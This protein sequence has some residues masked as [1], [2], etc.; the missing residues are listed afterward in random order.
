[1]T[2]EDIELELSGG[3]LSARGREHLDGCASCRETARL[4]GL[5][6]L[7]PV[8]EVERMMMN[9]LASGT[10]AAWRSKESRGGT[11]RRAASLA[12]AAGVGA[13]VAS[14]AMVKLRPVPEPEVRVQTIHITPPELPDIELVDSNLSDDEVF[15]D[16]GWPSPTEGDL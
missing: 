10:Q 7:P 3:T 12:M 2:C 8:T 9:S 4:L 1:M 14:V 6:A 13:L 11:F 5:A 16:V 15:F